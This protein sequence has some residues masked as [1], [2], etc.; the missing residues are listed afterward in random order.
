[1]GKLPKTCIIFYIIC[2]NKSINFIKIYGFSYSKIKTK[3]ASTMNTT[4]YY[5]YDNKNRQ[6]NYIEY[7][8]KDLPKSVKTLFCKY[9]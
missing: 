9:F 1:M 5:I 8:K 4:A 2:F 3:L 7:L 6:L